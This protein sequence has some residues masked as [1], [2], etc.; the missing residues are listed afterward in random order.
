MNEEKI[1]VYLDKIKSDEQFVN[2]PRYA[3]LLTFL[4]EK[5]I[6]NEPMKETSIG[7]EFFNKEYDNSDR[8]SGGIRVYMYNLRKKLNA[9]YDN[10]GREDS[11]K[12]EMSKGQYNISIKYQERIGKKMRR[13]CVYAAAIV[14]C[15]ALVTLLL[16]FSNRDSYCWANFFSKRALTTVVLADQ[17]TINDNI[18]GVKVAVLHPH[19]TNQSEYLEYIKRYNC[20]TLRMNSYSLYTKAIPFSMCSLTKWFCSHNKDFNT[21][22]ESEFNYIETNNSN[23]IYVGQSKTMNISR[24]IFLKNSKMFSVENETFTVRK[25]DGKELKYR[26]SFINKTTLIEYAMVSYMPLQNGKVALYFV[27]NNDVGTI[28]TVKRFVDAQWLKEFYENIPSNASYFNALFKVHGVSRNETKC[29]LV[30]LEIP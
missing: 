13:G 20:D 8:S 25:E 24:S 2:S 15:V 5:S 30:E 28:A 14:A 3:A 9:Y 27:S 6:A 7:V 23:I 21:I 26:S 18:N 19:I 11:V 22:S 4:V 1:R 29:E 16:T 10:Q 17:V 12:F